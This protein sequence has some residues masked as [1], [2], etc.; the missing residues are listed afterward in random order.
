MVS[1]SE[2]PQ[3]ISSEAISLQHVN[4]LKSVIKANSWTISMND[5]CIFASEKLVS[6]T[7]GRM[8][9]IKRKSGLILTPQRMI[10][11]ENL[12]DEI[13]VTVTSN[14]ETRRIDLG[15]IVN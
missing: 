8:T 6:L 1:G 7:S 12:E 9:S 14:P 11:R 3:L 2:I 13:K 5:T 15:C 4:E 10:Y